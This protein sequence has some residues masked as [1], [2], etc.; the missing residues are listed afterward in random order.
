M[1]GI[2]ILSVLLLIVVNVY[3]GPSIVG[4]F[5]QAGY[6]DWDP[7]DSLLEFSQNAN[8]VWEIT[9][10]LPA[11]DYLYKAVE[12]DDWTC[13]I[14]TG[15]GNDQ[16]LTLDTEQDVT[17]K[18]YMHNIGQIDNDEI[19]FENINTPA[20]VGDFVDELTG[21]IVPDW[22]YNDTTK[23]NDNG[24]NGDDVAGDDIYTYEAVIPAGDWEF[25]INAQNC[26]TPDGANIPFSSD[27]ITPTK[28]TFNVADGSF[29]PGI[30]SQDVTVTFQV[31]VSNLQEIGE[32]YLAGDFTNWQYEMEI[33]SDPDQD[34]I[35]TGEHFF[36]SGS[37]LSQEYKFVN[38]LEDTILI[39][40]YGANR[41]FI[42]DDSSPSQVL[43]VVAFYL[44]IISQDVT[45]TFQVDVSNL[46]EI[47]EIYLAG[48]FTAWTDSMEMLLDP[49]QDS[50]Y[51]GDHFF[52][53]GSL[54]EQQ[55]KFVNFVNDTLMWE[56]DPNRILIIDDSNPT[57]ILPIVTFNILTPVDDNIVLR[58]NTVILKNYPNPFPAQSGFQCIS[59]NPRT[60]IVFKAPSRYRN[61]CLSIY[62][63]LGQTIKE[64]SVKNSGELLYVDWDGTD[65]DNSTVGTGIY[66]YRL[67]SDNGRVLQ[68][69]KMILLK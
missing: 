18:V 41:S 23:M 44:G 55:Y 49:D 38:V 68:I 51:T 66:L 3:A 21:G 54:I 31:D 8:G 59:G 14:P 43:P 30:T 4:T 24:I 52:P 26:W 39:W 48:D 11:G 56:D 16:E 17:F 10:T 22:T 57:Q 47:G 15:T 69:R 46:D 13:P 33:L 37:S 6:T 2:S 1:R 42:I 32:I 53:A 50:V 62:N 65:S 29:T 64:Y 27:G 19:V 36:P 60:T 67:S 58:N 28:F 35:Y 5:A 25:K 20:V 45:V 12:T 9:L 61:L 40:E 34:S 63:I 7:A